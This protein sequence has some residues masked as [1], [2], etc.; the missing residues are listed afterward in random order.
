MKN[1]YYLHKF[2][3]TTNTTCEE[4]VNLKMF[5]S[6]VRHS[7]S[8]HTYWNIKNLISHFNDF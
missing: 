8:A 2:V 3:K 7:L 4:T 5:F 6:Y 1:K